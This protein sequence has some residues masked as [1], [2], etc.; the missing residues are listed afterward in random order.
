MQHEIGTLTNIKL[1]VNYHLVVTD[2]SRFAL[3]SSKS[4]SA[5]SNLWFMVICSNLVDLWLSNMLIWMNTAA[6]MVHPNPLYKVYY[7]KV[8]NIAMM[9][10]YVSCWWAHAFWYN[11]IIVWM[12]T[13]CNQQSSLLLSARTG[14]HYITHLEMFNYSQVMI[15]MKYDTE[16]HITVW[17]N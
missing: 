3:L 12:H 16:L 4:R 10:S 15:W 2:I 17:A 13:V 14:P 9:R 6:I 5:A 11:F 1:K 7:W 8:I